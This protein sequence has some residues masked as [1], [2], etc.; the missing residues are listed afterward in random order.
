[1][2]NHAGG[3]HPSVY[4]RMHWPYGECIGCHDQDQ[5]ETHDHPTRRSTG[6]PAAD[7]HVHVH[8]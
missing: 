6:V 5:E 1:M 3:T 8:V 7:A 2:N 4:W